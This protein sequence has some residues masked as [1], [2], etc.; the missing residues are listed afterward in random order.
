M[1]AF[2]VPICIFTNVCLLLECFSLIM[3]DLGFAL[4]CRS[5]VL[6]LIY[7]AFVLKK[8]LVKRALKK[9]SP[10][11]LF[12]HNYVIFLSCTVSA[13]FHLLLLCFLPQSRVYSVCV[14]LTSLPLAIDDY[15]EL[16]WLRERQHCYSTLLRQEDNA[17]LELAD[18]KLRN[19]IYYDAYKWILSYIP[20][21]SLNDT[22]SS[23]V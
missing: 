2:F 23:P 22:Y 13:T 12:F 14:V 3:E 4:A 21:R 17:G 16:E 20:R 6:M 19:S 18:C 8:D 7:L 10:K 11:L 5:I 15:I 1:D 9:K